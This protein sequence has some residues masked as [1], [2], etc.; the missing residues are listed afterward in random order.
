M[1]FF[2]ALGKLI[3]WAVGGW[4]VYH[5]TAD[6]GPVL[7]GADVPWAALRAAAVVCGRSTTGSAGRWRGPSGSLRSSTPEPE[8]VRR[9]AAMHAGDR[10][11]GGLRE[12]PV[13]LR[14][15]QSG[16][17][18]ADVHGQAGRDDRPGGQVGRGQVD[19]DQPALP[20][21][22]AGRGRI[23]IDG[24]DYREIALQDLRHQIGVVLQ[25]PFLF[26]GTIAENIAYGKPG[27][28]FEEIMAAAKAAN[29]PQLHPGQAGRLRHAGGREAEPSS[30][31]ASGSGSRSRAR[32]CTT[33]GS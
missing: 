15:V 17:Q 31:A 26:N 25:E 28:S 13:W 1:T 14:Q 27:A 11:A 3:H 18:G 23:S 6:A 9:R 29:A 30:R 20:V 32:S 19:H 33:R 22:R 16:H 12:R 21:L 4:M 10:G 7:D 2:I 8:N 24:V 5:G